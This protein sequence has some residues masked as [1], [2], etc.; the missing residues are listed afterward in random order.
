MYVDIVDKYIDIYRLRSNIDRESVSGQ[1]EGNLMDF[2]TM[3]ERHMSI[4]DTNR[5][6]ISYID[7]TADRDFYPEAE[8]KC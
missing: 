8:N 1:S 3:E 5:H 4:D 7:D 2:M 6:F